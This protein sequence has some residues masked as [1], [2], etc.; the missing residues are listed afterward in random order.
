MR[1][2]RQAGVVA[3]AAALVL[4]A[5]CNRDRAPA[6]RGAH[7]PGAPSRVREG[8]LVLL[9]VRREAAPEVADWAPAFEAASGCK[10]KLRYASDA[11]DLLVRAAG[12]GI[13]LVLAGGE[14]AAN[15]VAAGRVR[16]LPGASL[17]PASA[18]PMP[19]RALPGLQEGGLRYGLPVRWHPIVLGYDTRAFEQAPTSWSAVFAPA[20]EATPGLAAPDPIAI[21]DAAL[22]LAA[23]RP[24]LR[25]ADPYALDERQYAAVLSLLRQRARDWR[26]I[27]TDTTGIGEAI[28]NGVGA[29]AT[30]PARVAA[31]QSAG[32]PVAW[33]APEEGVGAQVEVAM[34]HAQAAHPNCASFWLQ[35]S[36]MPRGQA[37]LAARAGM[38]PVRAAA[39]TVEPLAGPRL[40]E[41]D[42]MGLMSQARFRRVPQASCGN[43]RCVPYSRWTRDYH[44]LL[45]Q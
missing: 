23:V 27:A 35:W 3:V 34:L 26:G 4:L 6:D 32:L 36:Q 20:G 39:C 8:A 2:G 21:A 33:A 25:I 38:L 28:G 18:L 45:G 15:L 43:R 29:F 44:A 14:V 30:A 16:P 9:E 5:A 31:L 41:R 13:D 12:S 10:L 7:D 17:P 42:G 1:K 24:E 40:C 11:G 22:Y 19:L 37:L